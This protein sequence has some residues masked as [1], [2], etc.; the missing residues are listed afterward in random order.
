MKERMLDEHLAAPRRWR[1]PDP[2]VF[3][4]NPGAD[5]YVCGAPDLPALRLWFG[6]Y[7]PAF[8][9][10]GARLACYEVPWLAVAQADRQQVVYQQRQARLLYVLNPGG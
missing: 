6:H 8:L 4:Q 7:L 3:K 2:T 1:E 10:S 5:R 9:T